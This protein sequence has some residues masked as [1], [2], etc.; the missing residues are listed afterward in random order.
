MTAV[1]FHLAKNPIT[2]SKLQEEL[3]L[4]IPKDT[5]ICTPAL[6]KDC[7]YLRACI[8]ESLR[9]R[10][11]VG[12]GLPRLTPPAGAKIAG[13]FIPGELPF[14]LPPGRFITIQLCSQIHSATSRSAGL[15]R[16]RGLCF[17]NILFPLAPEGKIL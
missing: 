7:S 6:I 8:D 4:A 12:I 16:K 2:Q 17:E 9:D 1:I 14:P 15:M 13:H 10:P 11:P 5:T 3:D